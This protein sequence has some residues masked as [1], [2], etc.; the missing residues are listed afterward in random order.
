MV[1]GLLQLELILYDTN[2]LKAKRSVLSR[3]RNHIQKKFNVSFSETGNQDLWQR[4]EISMTTASNDSA[5]ISRIFT[6][7]EK[8]IETT[9]QM[10]IIKRHMEVL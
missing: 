3:L 10:S 5:V 4:T 7:I 6:A 9:P 1:I 2:S 8:Q